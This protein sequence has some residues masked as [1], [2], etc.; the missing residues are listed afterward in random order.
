VH[1]IVLGAPQL[2][3]LPQAPLR[4]VKLLLKSGFRAPLITPDHCGTYL[5][6]YEFVPWSGGPPVLGATP[7]QVTEGCDTDGFAPKLQAGSAQSRAGS[8]SPFTFTIERDD[9][10]QNI[11]DLRVALPRGL[12]ASF[13]GIARCEGAAAVT[14]ECPPDSRVGKVVAAVGVGPQPLWIPQAGKRPTAVYLS[15]PY[16]GAPLSIVAVVPKQA[17]PF[18]FGDEVVRTAIRVDPATAEVTAV[19][20]PL[21]Q[22]VEGIPLFYKAI[23]V[24]LDRPHFSLNPTSCAPEQT[25]A[26]LISIGGA[27][28]SASAPYAATDCAKLGFGPRLALTLRGGT[29]RGA[30]PAFSA[31]FRPR[32]KDANTKSIVVTLPHSAFLDQAHIR[33]VC[34]RVQFAAGAGNGAECP[35]GSIYGRVTAY[36]PILDEPLEG[37]VFLRSSSHDLPDPGDGPA[38]PAQPAAGDRSRRPHR[39]KAGRHPHQLRSD[40]R[41]PP[42]QSRA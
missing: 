42:D 17:G 4:E 9:S 16:K 23:N 35:A 29:K 6:H 19:A 15:G 24:E 13:V 31:V 2:E 38:R 37:P 18:D 32:A 39:L 14:G 27:V 41:R 22:F 25:I 10:E 36:T 5:T 1:S 34:T 8:F 11:A 26:T 3:G 12:T 21:P 28:A 30:H 33:T 20:D 7:M 40:P